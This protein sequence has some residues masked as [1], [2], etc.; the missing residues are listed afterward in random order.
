MQS[1]GT[2]PLI[3]TN[4]MSTTMSRSPKASAAKAKKAPPSSDFNR[5]IMKFDGADSPAAIALSTL[6]VMGG[7]VFLIIWALQSAYT[8]G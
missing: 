2:R 7:I 3:P 8:I 6:V 4:A 1:T 5:G